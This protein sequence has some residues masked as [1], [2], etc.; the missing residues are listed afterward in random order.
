MC[1]IV[2]YIGGERGQEVVLTGLERLEYRGYD[3]AGIS[4]AHGEEFILLKAV[5]KLKELRKKIAQQSELPQ[6]LV[7][8]HTRWATHGAVTWDNAHPHVQGGISLVHNGIIENASTLRN[9]LI[10]E[11]LQFNSQTDSEVFLNLVSKYYEQQGESAIRSVLLAVEEVQGKS[12]FVVGFAKENLLLAIKTGAPLVC[13][14]NS[15]KGEGF[16]SSDPYAL[17]GF[18]EELYFPQDQTLCVLKE[19]AKAIDFVTLKEGEVV[20]VSKESITTTKIDQVNEVVSKSGFAHYM[21]KEIHE[22]PQC[23]QNLLDYYFSE[24]GKNTL[25]AFVTLQ[26]EHW[27]ISACGTAY[28]SGLL[29]KNFLE[30]RVKKSSQVFIASE[31]RY[32]EVF[33]PENCGALF[34]SQSGETADTIASAEKSKEKKL[35]ICSLVN[36]EHS[37]LSRLSD[38]VLMSLAGQEIGVASTKVFTQQSLVGYILANYSAG[39]EAFNACQHEVTAL[40]KSIANILQREDEVKKIAEK[41]YQ[42]RGFLFTGRGSLYSIALEAALKVKEINY[43]H[44]EGYATGE[45]KHGPIALFDH[46]MV[47]VALVERN[48]AQKSLVSLE[49][50]KSRQGIIFSI[51]PQIAELKER[52]DFFFAVA[53]E[54]LGDLYCLAVNVVTQ[55][56]AYHMACFNGTDIDQPRNLAKSVT[57]E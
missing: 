27:V 31:F 50:I 20:H 30:K 32:Q 3:S 55:L 7:V 10:S 53:D 22:Q 14:F 46:Q 26:R 1:G 38:L 57:V 37:S 18:G 52:S 5:G 2:G 41:I 21:H 9:Q 24:A 33:I 6:N 19:G 36:V 4:H 8:G 48:L 11:G 16:V 29:I 56:L 43:V 34:I 51:G 40:Q 25:D 49:E 13:S 15:V 17:V 54:G 28:H 47:N 45:L 23:I 39:P 35:P 44:A 42:K 12:A